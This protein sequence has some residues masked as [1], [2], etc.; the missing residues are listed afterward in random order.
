MPEWKS[1]SEKQ[2]DSW[3]Q[4]NVE[5]FESAQGTHLVDVEG[6]KRTAKEAWDE[7]WDQAWDSCK[8]Q[9]LSE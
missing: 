1:K 6:L 7:S 2:F 3:W 5:R 9:M 4:L 8:I